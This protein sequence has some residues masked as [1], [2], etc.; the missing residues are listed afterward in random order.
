MSVFGNL[1]RVLDWVRWSVKGHKGFTLTK[2]EI[3][4]GVT[5]QQF[6]LGL[7]KNPQGGWFWNV[8]QAT[9]S[10]LATQPP[11]VSSTD[12]VPHAREPTSNA[13]INISKLDKLFSGQNIPGTLAHNTLQ[14]KK[15]HLELREGISAAFSSFP[16]GSPPLENTG[17]TTKEVSTQ[18]T[19]DPAAPVKVSEQ[20]VVPMLSSAPPPQ[21]DHIS[22]TRAEKPINSTQQPALKRKKLLSHVRLLNCKH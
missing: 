15:E 17:H 10:P 9:T 11:T 19:P 8:D 1:P 7:E 2:D 5:A 14:V 22:A 16:I 13:G 3:Q 6:M 12:T 20:L 4:Y 21:K 18:A